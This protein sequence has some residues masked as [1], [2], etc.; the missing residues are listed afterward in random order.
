MTL[1]HIEAGTSILEIGSVTVTTAGTPVRIS[2]TTRPCKRIYFQ[3]DEGN[4][5]LN[6]TSVIAV[7]NSTVDAVSDPPKAMIQLYPTQRD[8]VPATDVSD[9]YIDATVDNSKASF[10]IIG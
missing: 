3:A 8:S 9:V 2:T 4:G 1:L 5:E 10:T 7:G 6:G